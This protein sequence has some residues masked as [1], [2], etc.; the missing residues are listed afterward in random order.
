MVDLRIIELLAD[1]EADDHIDELLAE[2]VA[3]PDAEAINTSAGFLFDRRL[4]K[5]KRIDKHIVVKIVCDFG[6]AQVEV[7]ALKLQ[8]RH[9]PIHGSTTPPSSVLKDV[10]L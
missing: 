9:H 8:V 6:L 3:N 7:A 1:L 2:F 4:G 10:R 5:S